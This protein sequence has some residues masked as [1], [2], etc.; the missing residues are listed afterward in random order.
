MQQSTTYA[1]IDNIRNR[2]ELSY[3]LNFSSHLPPNPKI[4]KWQITKDNILTDGHKFYV[5]DNVSIFDDCYCIVS[6]DA[7]CNIVVPFHETSKKILEARNAKSLCHWTTN[8][9]LKQHCGYLWLSA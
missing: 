2:F 9:D 1:T 3:P 8:D 6:T 4:L 7:N 5:I